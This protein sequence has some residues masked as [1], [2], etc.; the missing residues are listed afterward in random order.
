MTATQD[1]SRSYVPETGFGLWFQRTDM[2]RRYVVAEAV[3]ELRSLVP[4]DTPPFARVLD[5]GCGEG[6][7]FDMLQQSFGAGTV[8]GVDIDEDSVRRASALAERSGG[9]IEV[10]RADATKLPF[11]S[12]SFD[13]VFCHQLL[14]HALDPPAVLRECHRVLAPG[15]WLLIAESCRV[16]LDS[17][18][19]RLFF[20]HPPRRQQ[21]AEEYVAWV[22]AADFTLTRDSWMTPSPWWSLT[23]AGA[24][25]QLGLAGTPRVPTQV[26]IAVRRPGST[27]QA[28]P[29]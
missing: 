13:M 8:I 24:L 1:L 4:V 20:R 28:T 17:W 7:A 21:T 29:R 6:V 11:E 16:F 3:G 23:D 27:Q 22:S 2:W 5:I 15:G 9:C 18:W 25:R 10:R 26:R 14:H 19:V 12:G